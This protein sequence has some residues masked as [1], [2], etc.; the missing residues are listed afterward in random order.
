MGIQAEYC[1]GDLVKGRSAFGQNKKKGVSTD[2]VKNM[3]K[4]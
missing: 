2:Y 4:Y 1:L 3:L